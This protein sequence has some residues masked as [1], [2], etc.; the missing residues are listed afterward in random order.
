[1]LVEFPKLKSLAR[2]FFEKIAR[3]FLGE[4]AR[5]VRK[6]TWDRMERL[7]YRERLRQAEEAGDIAFIEGEISKNQL[8]PSDLN[9]IARKHTPIE[10]WPE[11]DDDIMGT[12]LFDVSN[13]EPNCTQIR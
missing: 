3:I 6:S 7:A 2:D 12:T 9:R 13:K 8:T 5:I 11:I 4:P 1:M 10:E